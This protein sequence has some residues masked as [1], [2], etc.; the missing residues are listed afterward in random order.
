MILIVSASPNRDGLTADCATAAMTAIRSAG[1]TVQLADLYAEGV[2]SCQT[3]GNGW[4]LCR[5]ERRCFIDDCLPSLVHRFSECKSF[6]LV[7]PVYWGQPSEPMQRF[8][9]RFRR[10]QNAMLSDKPGAAQDKRADLIAAAGGSG[11]GTVTCLAEMELW[12]RHVGAVPLERIGVNRFNRDE[13]LTM[14][15]KNAERMVKG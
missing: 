13:M 1:G 11:N 3:C 9:G 10:C 2:R 15:A 8:L 6:I 5:R 12:C 14:I 7:T 4:G